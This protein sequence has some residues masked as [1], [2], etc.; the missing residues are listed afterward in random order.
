MKSGV[1]GPIKNTSIGIFSFAH[2]PPGPCLGCSGPGLWIIGWRPEHTLGDCIHIKSELK[3]IGLTGLIT[4]DCFSSCQ[5]N[6][7]TGGMMGKD[8]K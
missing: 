8:S 7:S 1:D 4:W 2:V 5:F 3:S 6:Q